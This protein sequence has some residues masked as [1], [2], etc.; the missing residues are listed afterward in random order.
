MKQSIFNRYSILGV[1][2]SF[3]LLLSPAPLLAQ[4]WIDP[5]VVGEYRNDV[6]FE[7]EFD[8]TDMCIWADIVEFDFSGLAF[9]TGIELALVVDEP[10]PAS[11]ELVVNV[12]DPVAPSDLFPITPSTTGLSL[13]STTGI[14]TIR[15][16][17]TAHGTPTI[18][19]EIYSCWI[20]YFTDIEPC[21]NTFHLI[22]A[23][24]F[25]PCFTEL[26]TG[27]HEAEKP[28]F[29]F[30]SQNSQITISPD[31]SGKLELIDIT[32]RVLHS[33]NVVQGTTH[34]FSVAL[35]GIIIAR[36]TGAERTFSQK[37][38]IN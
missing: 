30:A 28:A 23:E 38:F 6:V 34:V 16:H 18:A 12:Y 37:I 31:I 19:E 32:G 33:G 8:G 5:Y 4:T 17:L 2:Q 11:T 21:W 15:F 13:G 3:L 35:S 25:V 24:S 29:S 9:P 26:P 10:D 7:G 20:E 36:L 22:T 14:A 27:I 1:L